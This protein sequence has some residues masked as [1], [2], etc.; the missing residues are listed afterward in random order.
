ME[1]P[2]SD[3]LF[4]SLKNL[5]ETQRMLLKVKSDLKEAEQ[6]LWNTELE[7]EDLNGEIAK[8][9]Y[10]TECK[11]LVTSLEEK[12]KSLEDEVLKRR[13]ILEN[14]IKRNNNLVKQGIVGK[15]RKSFQPKL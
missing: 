12:I 10:L 9:P 2:L 11:N 1:P 7:L 8:C 13:E 15:T 5:N 6:E 4:E 14:A 3:L